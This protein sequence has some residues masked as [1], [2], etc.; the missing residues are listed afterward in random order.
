MDSALVV[1]LAGTVIAAFVTGL[2]GFAFGLVAA[3]IWLH[4]LSP[5]DAATLI[6]AYALLVQG[7]AVWKLRRAIDLARLVPFVVGSAVGIPGGIVV[8]RLVSAESLRTAVGALLVLF[9]L[10]NLARPKLAAVKVGGRAAD[11]VVGIFNGVL[12][13]A[14]GLGP[15]GNLEHY[16]RLDAR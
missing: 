3:G 4:A 12:S 8:L 6:V 14:T 5:V 1:F 2:A 16:A 15:A 9:S 13:G 11:G 10:Y 7:Y